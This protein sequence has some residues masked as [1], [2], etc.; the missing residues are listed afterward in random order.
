MSY[1]VIQRVGKYQYIFLATGYRSQDG[2][3]RQK[4]IPIGKVYST[5][6]TFSMSGS[7]YAL[8]C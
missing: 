5:P 8:S 7:L 4:R 1:E 6:K 2:K 3:V